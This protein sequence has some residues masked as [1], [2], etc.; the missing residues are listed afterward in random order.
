MFNSRINSKKILLTIV[1]LLFLFPQL[2]K[3]Q[4]ADNVSSL[5]LLNVI[6]TPTAGVLKQGQYQIDLDAFGNGGT[7]VGVSMG[8]FNRFMFG[9]SYGGE[10]LIG[11]D[12]VKGNKFPGVLVKY[13]IFEESYVMPAITVGFDMQGRGAW[14]DSND[15]YLFKAPGGFAAVSRNWISNVGRFGVHL[16]ANYN[17]IE[18]ENE[19]SVDGFAGIDFSLNEQLAL[20]IE[21]DLALDDKEEDGLFGEG[22][23]GYL[24]AGVRMTFAQSLVL[25]F[26]VIDIL[27]S[28][29]Q[30]D[31]RGREIRIV[32]VETF[33]F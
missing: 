30:N 28:S 14:Y 33:T 18:S 22:K 12:K 16:G 11:Y 10:G 9:I 3:A 32:Y 8:L 25:Q 26:D 21:Y 17:T 20:N 1:V 29:A 27:N 6:H 7:L 24:N 4:M 5:E 13:R 15:R 19:Q 31:G 2:C 23:A